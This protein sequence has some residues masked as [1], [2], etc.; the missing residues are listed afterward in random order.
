VLRDEMSMALGHA[1]LTIIAPNQ[2]KPLEVQDL[3]RALAK[4]PDELHSA[5][6]LVGMEGMRYE[7]AAAVLGVPVG[8]IRSRLSRGREALR[9]FMGAGSESGELDSDTAQRGRLPASARS[10]ICNARPSGVGSLNLQL[11]AHPRNLWVICRLFLRDLSVRL[12][13]RASRE[14]LSMALVPLIDVGLGEDN[15]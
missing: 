15:R 8:T 1:E 3:E 13:S 9:Q 2:E 12:A 5:L 10:E 6:L 11:L 14:A 4:L 7:Q